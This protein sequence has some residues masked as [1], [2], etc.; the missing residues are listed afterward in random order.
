MIVNTT[1]KPGF[2]DSWSWDGVVMWCSEWC[3]TTSESIG[4]YRSTTGSI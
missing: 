1:V 3:S 4:L 2:S